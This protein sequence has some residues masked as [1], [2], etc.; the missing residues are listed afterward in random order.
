MKHVSLI[1]MFRNSLVAFLKIGGYDSFASRRVVTNAAQLRHCT[2]W[3]QPRPRTD[4]AQNRNV[5]AIL[6]GSI[7]QRELF[8]VLRC[9]LQFL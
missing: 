2:E 3:V 9:G 5:I 7:R 8:V 1:L 4:I 6:W